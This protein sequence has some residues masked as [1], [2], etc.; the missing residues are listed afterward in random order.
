MKDQLMRRRTLLSAA[1]VAGAAVAT[2]VPLT[3]AAAE[4]RPRAKNGPI[5]VAYVE[6]NNNSMLNV[7]KYTLANGGAQVFD[8]AVIFAANINYDGSKAYLHFNENV[9][10]VL[11]NVATEVRPLQQKG[12]KVLLS[13]LGNHQ[14]AGFANFPSQAAADAFAQELA[15]AVNQYGLDGIDFDDEYADY[16]VNGTPQPNASSFV[17]LV[18][19]LRQ[20]LPNK[21]ITLYDIGPAA[22]RLSYNGQSV[23]ETFNYAW[24]PYY[25]TW[26]VPRGPSAKSKLSPAAVHINVS[27]NAASLATRTK[28]EGYGVF[29]TYD[30]GAG[31]ASSYISGFTNPLYGSN[32]VYTA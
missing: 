19:A 12:I 14:G 10:R 20:K 18:Q 16:G 31:N 28:T 13:I 11:D 1:A 30:L 3:A 17:Y 22:A 27:S 21:L 2:G 6:V 29:L 15:D 5:S 4:C 23:A 32:A 24:N 25:G 9:Q 7:G 8:V 26:S